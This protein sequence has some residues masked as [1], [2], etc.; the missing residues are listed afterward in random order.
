MA[1]LFRARP[2]TAIFIGATSA[3][4]GVLFGLAISIRS[5]REVCIGRVVSSQAL[6]S[7]VLR[8]PR[9]GAL[10]TRHCGSLRKAH[11]FDEFAC[12]RADVMELRAR[13]YG[14]L[15]RKARIKLMLQG[16]AMGQYRNAKEGGVRMHNVPRDCIACLFDVKTSQQPMPLS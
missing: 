5:R 4:L 9:F 16:A 7:A 6:H 3:H 14:P 11:R 1:L 12:Q 13:F 2:F 10:W 15:S 8:A